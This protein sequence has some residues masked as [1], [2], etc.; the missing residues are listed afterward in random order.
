MVASRGVMDM[1]YR[2]TEYDN[3]AGR[4]VRATE[5]VTAEQAQAIWRD[6][7]GGQANAMAPYAGNSVG[8]YQI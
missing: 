2:V 6:W 8:V 4:I 7:S 3:T 5:C 1:R